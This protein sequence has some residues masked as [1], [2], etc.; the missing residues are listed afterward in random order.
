MTGILAGLIGSLKA[1]AAAVLNKY[2]V[3]PTSVGN[4]PVFSPQR[5]VVVDSDSNIYFSHNG[6]IYK[7]RKDATFLWAKSHGGT[8]NAGAN[9]AVDS[10]TVY[11][12]TVDSSSMIVITALNISD[13]TVVW[14]KKTTSTAN[15]YYS[16]PIAILNSTQ[17]VTAMNHYPTD[18]KD[19]DD[20]YVVLINKS[21]GSMTRYNGIGSVIV[22]LTVDPSQN[23]WFLTDESQ[24]WKVNSTLVKQQIYNFNHDTIKFDSSGNFYVRAGSYVAKYNS[25]LTRVWTKRITFPNYYTFSNR[26]NNN[27]IDIDSS[28]NVYVLPGFERIG[29]CTTPII[30]LNSSDG[31]TAWAIKITSSQ[32]T[33]YESF[34]ATIRVASDTDLLLNYGTLNLLAKIQTNGTAIGPIGTYPNF[35]IAN[36][37]SATIVTDNAYSFFATTTSGFG[38]FPTNGSVYGWSTNTFTQTSTTTDLFYKIIYT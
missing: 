31:S 3:S 17:I 14:S 18:G 1:A 21:D 8:V 26:C 24:S 16:S 28:G 35:S 15:T 23:I 12:S 5:D 10:T 38:N 37:T 9:L 13:G 36:Y 25:S 11:V 20:G 19:P 27:L 2:F 34:E 22:T 33:G 30:K 6:F 4:S 29:L 32:N 7:F